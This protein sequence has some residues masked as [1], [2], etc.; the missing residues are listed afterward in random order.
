MYRMGNKGTKIHRLTNR[1]DG[2]I[3]EDLSIKIL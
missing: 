2:A 1:I 3:R